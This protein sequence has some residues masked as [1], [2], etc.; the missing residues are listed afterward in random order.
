LP[1]R[2]LSNV[3]SCLKAPRQPFIPEKPGA[4]LVT[5]VTQKGKNIC[6]KKAQKAHKKHMIFLGLELCQFC[7]SSRQKSLARF[8][9]GLSGF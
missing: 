4:S 7:A 9:S 8:G 5:N 6:R 1:R 3:L 2:N